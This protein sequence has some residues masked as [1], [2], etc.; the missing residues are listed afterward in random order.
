[1]KMQKRQIL[2]RLWNFQ[3]QRRCFQNDLSTAMSAQL[4]EFE[5]VNSLGEGSIVAVIAPDE[6]FWIACLGT[7]SGYLRWSGIWLEEISWKGKRANNTTRYRV[8][9]GYD[10]ATIWIDNII[11][12]I[13][14][15]IQK[16][17]DDVWTLHSATVQQLHDMVERHRQQPS[18]THAICQLPTT[19]I[20][21]RKILTWDE[22]TIRQ[23]AEKCSSAL[24]LVC[25]FLVTCAL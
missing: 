11:C 6:E 3:K 13:S 9:Q 16:E 19:T 2:A 4:Q 17:G 1:M 18:Q 21:P 23:I 8:A 15:I 20:S 12:N 7:P 5:D 14:H 10:E 25:E 22:A 24:K